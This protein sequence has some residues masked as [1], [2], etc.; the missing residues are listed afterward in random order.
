[1]HHLPSELAVNPGAERQP[2]CKAVRR[3]LATPAAGLRSRTEVAIA[4]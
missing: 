3:T 4:N 1:M 2:G